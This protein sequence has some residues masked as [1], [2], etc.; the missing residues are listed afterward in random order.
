MNNSPPFVE[1]SLFEAVALEF[2]LADADPSP[3]DDTNVW[4]DELTLLAEGMN[5][6]Q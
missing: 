1:E 2:A 5:K 4:L 6:C 3:V